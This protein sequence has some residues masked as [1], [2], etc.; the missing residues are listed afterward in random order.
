LPVSLVR[1][2]VSPL[3]AVIPNAHHSTFKAG[4]V[5]RRYAN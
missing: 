2:R 1:R 5:R 4:A 3:A